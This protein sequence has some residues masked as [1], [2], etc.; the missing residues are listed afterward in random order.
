[1]A[2]HFRGGR[3][4]RFQHV[5]DQVNPPAR[6]IQFV[7]EQHERGARRG[8]EAAMHAGAQNLVAGRGIRVGKLRGTEGVNYQR[9]AE[10]GKVSK[11]FF[12]EKKNQKTFAWGEPSGAFSRT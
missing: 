12:F 6:T 7:S 5:L 10:K 1:M 3:A 4:A 8:A 11:Q 9:A 2:H